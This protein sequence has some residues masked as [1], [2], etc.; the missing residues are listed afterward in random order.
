MKRIVILA[1]AGILLGVALDACLRFALGLGT[2]PL[3]YADPDYGYAFKPNQSL[4]RFGRRI[5]YNEEGLRSP[6]INMNAPCRIL[7]LGDSVT[8]GG[9]LTDQEDT[10]PYVLGKKLASAGYNCEIENA[11][12]GSWGVENE[13]EFLKKR[14]IFGS[15]WVVA[16]IGSHDLYQRKSTGEKVGVDPNFASENPP[17]ASWELI[18]RYAIP[19]LARFV[20]PARH[21]NPQTPSPEDHQACMRTIAEMIHFVREH[22]AEIMLVL[23]PDHVEISAPELASAGRKSIFDLSES[24]EVP[25]IDMLPVFR[26]ETDNGSVVFRDSVHPNELGNAAMAESAFAVLAELGQLQ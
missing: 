8:N 9:V 7:C 16:Q 25:L 12:A 19:R 5:E 17:F 21:V 11:S 4:R 23:T 1:V 20:S 15:D 26:E 22:H 24:E 6:P 13:L 14:G 2:P 3:S 18:E 10:Y